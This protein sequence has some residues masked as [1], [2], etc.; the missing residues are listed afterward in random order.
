M[1]APL[2]IDP[3][4]EAMCPSLDEDEYRQLEENIFSEGLV[5]MPLIVCAWMKIHPL[6]TCYP[7][8]ER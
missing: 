5:L 7:M 3:E 1:N 6:W 4:Y 8:T 2:N